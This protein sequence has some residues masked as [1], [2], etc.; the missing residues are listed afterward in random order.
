MSA[1][2]IKNVY[3][4][5]QKRTPIL[6]ERILVI[7]TDI[8]VPQSRFARAHPDIDDL[9]L[10]LHRLKVRNPALFRE[11]DTV[12]IRGPAARR[13]PDGDTDMFP[14]AVSRIATSGRWVSSAHR[15]PHDARMSTV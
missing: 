14:P 13:S 3:I 1:R 8:D 7:E 15:V 4:S 5:T 11:V 12:E 9:L 6:C 10:E 2:H